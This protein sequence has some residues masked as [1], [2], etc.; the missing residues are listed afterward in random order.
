MN[1]IQNSHLIQLFSVPIFTHVWDDCEDM[2][3]ELLGVILEQEKNVPSVS[4]TNAGGWQSKPQSP[5]WAGKA[6]E[7]LASRIQAAIQQATGELLRQAIKREKMSWQ[8]SIWANVNRAGD[9][10][11]MH[12]HAGSTWSG[13]YYVDAGDTVDSEPYSGNISF[14]NPLIQDRS[15]FFA[16]CFPDR[17]FMRVS[18]G[19]ILLFP[20]YLQHEVRRYQGNRPRVSIAFNARKTPYP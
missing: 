5:G 3:R 4:L 11:E 7:E 8:F 20:S 13:V 14:L 2:N 17:Q 19:Q 16:N 12:I 18:T 9:Y 10:N 15:C 6:G 1:S